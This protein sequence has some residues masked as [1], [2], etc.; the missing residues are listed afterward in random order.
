MRFRLPALNALRAF[1]A[2]ARHCSFT[3]AANELCVGQ[4]AVSRHIVGLERSLGIALF[5]R[6]HRGVS[7][8]DAG[9]AYSQTLHQAFSL[10]HQG[11]ALL[12]SDG[13]A[14]IVRVMAPPTFASRWL[15]PRLG[16]F[17]AHHPQTEVRISTSQDLVDFERD[18][19]DL[20]IAYGSGNWPRIEAHRLIDECL[21][22]VCRPQLAGARPP[23]STID[24]L[25]RY[26]FLHSLK[27]PGEWRRW[28]DF[29]GQPDVPDL[30]GLRFGASVLA[31]QAAIDGL[32]LA[33][34]QQEFV[35]DELNAHRLMMPFDIHLRTGNA[36][37]VTNAL[38]H[39]LP[40]AVEAFRSWLI[41]QARSAP[42]Q[43]G[44]PAAVPLEPAVQSRPARSGAK[45]KRRR[46]F[47][48]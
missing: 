38:K 37:F 14:A 9:K 6:H 17:S 1:E 22:M 42:N 18:E 2:A 39:R 43:E 26:V 8:T 15:L 27:R 3:E 23:P 36:Y 44:G 19:F 24:E 20:A 32:G 10:I 45:P 28:L 41:A 4:G 48:R 31:Y 30:G 33:I 13:D 16:D 25:R 35:S 29:V 34:A 11:T 12:R 46:S 7:L 47:A 21:V 40:K 5:H